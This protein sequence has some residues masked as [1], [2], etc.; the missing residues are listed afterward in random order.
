MKKRKHSI[1]TEA[2][3]EKKIKKEII[4]VSAIGIKNSKKR[5]K[6][7]KQKR[8]DADNEQKNSSFETSDSE[9]NQRSTLNESVDS[10]VE[11]PYDIKPSDDKKDSN[12][13]SNNEDLI[14]KKKR[15]R[16]KGKKVKLEASITSPEL[17][18]MSK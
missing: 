11:K 13:E 16:N 2:V 17:R 5:K 6:K 3:K 4:K 12:I 1:S 8:S 7:D 14:I 10:I 18:I 9:Y 15:K